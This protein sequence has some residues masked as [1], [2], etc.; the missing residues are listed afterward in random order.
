MHALNTIGAHPRHCA[1]LLITADTGCMSSMA[2]L[3]TLSD[4]G[5]STK[6]LIPVSTQMRSAD[7]G[8]IQLLGAIFIELTSTNNHGR[9]LTTKQMVYISAN[10]QAFYLSRQGCEDL[11]IISENFPTIDETGIHMNASAT[12]SQENTL[13]SCGCPK[14]TLPPPITKP[15][16]PLTDENRVEIENK[17]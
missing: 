4:L 9:T 12:E 8:R 5:L 10:T 1:N 11:K 17:H 7:N 16:F 6:A 15:A 13:A 14:R 2:G 3:N